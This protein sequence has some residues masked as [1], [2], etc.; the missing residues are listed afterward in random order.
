MVMAGQYPLV[1]L[2]S[3][4][5]NSNICFKTNLTAHHSSF[6]TYPSLF[7]FYPIP[8]EPAHLTASSL[9]SFSC[10]W[11]SAA[12]GY[13]EPPLMPAS[14]FKGF[15]ECQYHLECFYPKIY[16]LQ[17]DFYELEGTRWHFQNGLCSR[18][19]QVLVSTSNEGSLDH[20]YAT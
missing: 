12:P 4:F 5:L 18:V 3:S 16:V 17:E 11:L 20:L 10:V 2:S 7:L 6:K 19:P 13:D 14:N 15:L 1:Q 9:T 8:S